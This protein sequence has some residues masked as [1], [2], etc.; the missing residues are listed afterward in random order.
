MCRFGMP[1]E[2]NDVTECVQIKPTVEGKDYGRQYSYLD[3]SASSFQSSNSVC[4]A[5]EGDADKRVLSP[6]SSLLNFGSTV[7]FLRTEL[8]QC[9]LTSW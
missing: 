6:V 8:K 9:S 3:P 7:S 5:V 1:K 2:K 4:Q